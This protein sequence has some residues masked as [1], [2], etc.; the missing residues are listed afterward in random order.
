[1]TNRQPSPRVPTHRDRTGHA[2]TLREIGD[3][4]DTL[5]SGLRDPNAQLSSD[6]WGN[7]MATLHCAREQCGGEI[8]ANINKLFAVADDT[9]RSADRRLL[10]TLDQL[11][12][13][14]QD[15]LHSEQTAR[16]TN[17]PNQSRRR[18]P[19]VAQQP[20]FTFDVN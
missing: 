13:S 17:T 16:P 6:D 18:A 2:L 8:R 9:S 3:V 14:I 1:V 15:A 7:V 12:S 4:V 11:A 20:L 19:V 5:R 10:T